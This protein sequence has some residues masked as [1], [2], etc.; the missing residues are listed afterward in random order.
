M[1]V[2]CRNTKC[3]NIKPPK[4]AEIL[5]TP[6]H[7]PQNHGLLTTRTYKLLEFKLM[8]E[9]FWVVDRKKT[10]HPMIADR[11]YGLYKKT[12]RNPRNIFSL[13]KIKTWYWHIKLFKSPKSLSI[14]YFF[15]SKHKYVTSDFHFNVICSQSFNK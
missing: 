11:T 4:N 7:S 13:I 2:W 9:L 8:T 6:S 1:M 5:T 15:G 3:W 10:E 14:G 12:H